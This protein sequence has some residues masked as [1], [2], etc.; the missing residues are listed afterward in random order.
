MTKQKNN[1]CFSSEQMRLFGEGSLTAGALTGIR[2]HADN[3]PMC[4]EV[5]ENLVPGN[6][7]AILAIN[8]RVNSRIS[9]MV[10]TV[11]ALPFYKNYKFLAAIL[12]LFIFTA[13]F[14]LYQQFI[15]ESQTSSSGMVKENIN[16]NHNTANSGEK[17]LVVNNEEKPAETINNKE[18]TII[19]NNNVEIENKVNEE[20]IAET[21]TEEVEEPI[22]TE[23]RSTTLSPGNNNVANTKAVSVT[24]IEV[25]LINM[26]SSSSTGSRSGGNRGELSGGKIKHG[27]YKVAD[28]PMY[29]G[30]ESHLKAYLT[31][32]IWDNVSNPNSLLGES[33]VLF[34]DINSK[35][36]IENPDVFGKI[37]PETKSE[38]IKIL[39]EM[40]RWQQ[41]KGKGSVTCTMSVSFK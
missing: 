30:G 24:K 21:K 2:S 18:I 26:V 11:P 28:M 3:C 39:E 23:T 13:G 20:V 22:I 34:F 10:E 37:S 40:P 19:E 9:L 41:G 4:A 14:Y 12:A 7:S 29:P 36:K 31:N 35:G 27:N 33:L 16:N 6:V 38:I 8:E 17:I 5:L 32:K 15:P 25:Q 1:T